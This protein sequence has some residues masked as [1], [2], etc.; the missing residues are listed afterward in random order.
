M[1]QGLTKRP[2]NLIFF[3]FNSV[4]VFAVL[5]LSEKEIGKF[6]RG[7]LEVK[8]TDRADAICDS[9]LPVHLTVLVLNI[10]FNTEESFQ[11]HPHSQ[12]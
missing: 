12:S 8:L 1:E 10:V 2:K 4:V 9:C 7:K 6:D 11:I 5:F 3:A